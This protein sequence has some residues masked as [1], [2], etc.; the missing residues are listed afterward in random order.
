MTTTLTDEQRAEIRAAVAEWP[1]L[2]LAQRDTVATL[3]SER[4]VKAS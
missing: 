1:P 3:F 2:T 4:E